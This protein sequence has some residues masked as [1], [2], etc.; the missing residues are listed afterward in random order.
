[1]PAAAALL[2]DSAPLGKLKPRPSKSIS[3]SHF[4]IGF[5]TLDRRMFDPER[6]Y[7]HLAQ[8]GVMGLFTDRPS[9]LLDLLW[10]DR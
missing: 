7:G 4:S 9:A 2:T 10:R 6:T 1:M 5:E 3:G 8:L